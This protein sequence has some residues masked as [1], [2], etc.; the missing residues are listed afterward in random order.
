MAVPTFGSIK[1]SDP[2]PIQE[3]WIFDNPGDLT[4]A[5]NN[6]LDRLATTFTSPPVVC[7]IVLDLA[8][9]FYFATTTADQYQSVIISAAPTSV[10][11]PTA[12][13]G[14]TIADSCSVAANPHYTIPVFGYWANVPASTSVS[15]RWR[16]AP[17][18]GPM[19]CIYRQAFGSYRIFRE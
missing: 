5:A 3:V 6:T 16:I 2:F 18:G 17:G 7:S 4:V 19:S 12:N 11:A 8:V 15:L 13:P 1:A 10:P 9:Y 14:S